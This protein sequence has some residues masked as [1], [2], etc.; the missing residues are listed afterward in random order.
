M[1]ENKSFMK[2]LQAYEKIR[3]MILCG[4]KLPGTILVLSEL[5][6][7]QGI[8]RGPIREDR[9]RADRYGSDLKY[10]ETVG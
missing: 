7:E 2:T 5:E 6:A 10:P 8:G 4:V 9:M 1:A 3:D